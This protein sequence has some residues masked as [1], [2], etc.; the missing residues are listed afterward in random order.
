VKKFCEKFFSISRV[1][2]VRKQ[3]INFAQGEAEGIDQAWERFNGLIKQGPRIGFSSDVLLHTFYFSLTPECMR[4]VQMCVGGNIMEK[5]LT[6][7][8]QLQQR[9]SEG[10]AVQRYWEEHISG[11]VEQE[12]CEGPIRRTR[13]GGSEWEPIKILLEG[14]EDSNK[15]NTASNTRL[16]LTTQN[17]QVHVATGVLLNLGT[18]TQPSD[19]RTQR[20]TKPRIH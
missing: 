1:Q 11:S 3:V 7:A 9:I 16:R 10:V 18:N 4:Y 17:G 5:I 2:N 12:T 14:D 6:E 15:M 20:N 8:T 19:R 13:E